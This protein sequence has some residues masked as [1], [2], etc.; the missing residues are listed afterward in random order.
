M[1][2]N[3]IGNIEDMMDLP[4]MPSQVRLTRWRLAAQI[5]PVN[6][7]PDLDDICG[8]CCGNVAANHHV[9]RVHDLSQVHD[10][11]SHLRLDADTLG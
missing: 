5:N 11:V 7:H 3:C 10:G 2:D 1:N 8:H 6:F 9:P 4:S